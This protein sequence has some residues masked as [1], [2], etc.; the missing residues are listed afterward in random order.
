MYINLDINKKFDLEIHVYYIKDDDF[1]LKIIK[2]KYFISKNIYL[3]Q[4]EKFSANKNFIAISK[5]KSIHFFSINDLPL[6]KLVIN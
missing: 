6:Q 4:S 1:L 5:Q 2:V 3:N